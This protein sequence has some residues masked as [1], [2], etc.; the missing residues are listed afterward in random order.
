MGEPPLAND[1]PVN[2]FVCIVGVED[3]DATLK[4]ILAAGGTVALDKMDV[5]TVGLLAYC[6][7]PEGTL[8]G[9]PQPSP[10]MTPDK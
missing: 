8:F 9:V 4:K 7:D 3:I 10:A 2:A 5:P 6:K 1:T